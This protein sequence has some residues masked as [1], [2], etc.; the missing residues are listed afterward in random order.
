MR[1]REGNA[2]AFAAR[3]GAT[4]SGLHSTSSVGSSIASIG[5]TGGALAGLISAQGPG[6]NPSQGVVTVSGDNYLGVYD[7]A[8][9]CWAVVPPRAVVICLTPAEAIAW[10]KVPRPGRSGIGRDDYH[11]VIE[12][13]SLDEGECVATHHLDAPDLIGWHWP[14]AL[15]CAKRHRYRVIRLDSRGEDDSA[16]TYVVRLAD[17]TMRRA[18]D[19][20]DAER[21]AK[22]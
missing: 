3:F 13:W 9:G 2:P 1:R 16:R 22:W 11:W 12:L 7:R 15:H 10:T 18:S 21:L 20:A 14:V 6:A 4:T 5:V 19:R 8:Y 17:G